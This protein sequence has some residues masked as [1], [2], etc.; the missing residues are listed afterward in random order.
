MIALWIEKKALKKIIDAQL[1]YEYTIIQQSHGIIVTLLVLGGVSNT[2]RIIVY[3][4]IVII[5]TYTS[6]KKECVTRWKW[7]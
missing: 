3:G 7:D 2:V 1:P 5:D 4:S 6:F